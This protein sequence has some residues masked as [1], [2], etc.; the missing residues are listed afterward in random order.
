[1]LG[2]AHIYNMGTTEVAYTYC[3]MV[4]TPVATSAQDKYLTPYRI[5]N[6]LYPI[7]NFWGG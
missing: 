1:M 4:N 3:F 6:H 5:R 7:I 2:R